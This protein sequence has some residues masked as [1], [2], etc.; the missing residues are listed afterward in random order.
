MIYMDKIKLIHYF[1]RQA[2][3]RV[4]YRSNTEAIWRSNSAHERNNTKYFRVQHRDDCTKIWDFNMLK[5]ENKFE[6]VS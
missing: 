2:L 6:T 5:E 1:F 4:T 3:V